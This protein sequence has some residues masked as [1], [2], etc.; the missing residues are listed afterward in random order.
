VGRGGVALF[1]A[2]S[3][4]ERIWYPSMIHLIMVNEQSGFTVKQL[5]EL[6]KHSVIFGLVDR[7]GPPSALCKTI[8][9]CL[10]IGRLH[11]SS[12]TGDNGDVVKEVR[13]SMSATSSNNTRE[14]FSDC[15]IFCKH[16]SAPSCSS[17]N[18]HCDSV[19]SIW[20]QVAKLG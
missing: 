10:F 19:R 3:L 13:T 16:C 4:H 5:N 12:A 9:M 18:P 7:C 2:Q 20:K 11:F 15:D 1:F 8:H 14:A 17:Q 6:Y